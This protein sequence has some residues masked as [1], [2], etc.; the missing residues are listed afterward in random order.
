MADLAGDEALQ[1]PNCR[2]GVRLVAGNIALIVSR[3]DTNV[4]PDLPVRIGTPK[5]AGLL[6]GL[7]DHLQH[8]ALLG[9]GRRALS[10]A[11][12][13]ELMIKG[14]VV[15]DEVAKPLSRVS[16]VFLAPDL[17]KVKPLAGHLPVLGL[18]GAEHIP[19]FV[20]IIGTSHL[21]R[22]AYDRNVVGLTGLWL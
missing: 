5:V 1:I 11:L 20:E 7:V 6:Y 18:S 3:A 12:F 22:H 14:V 19:K 10:R 17:V 4:A 15:V 2:K 13:E 16:R 21:N 8:L 9:V